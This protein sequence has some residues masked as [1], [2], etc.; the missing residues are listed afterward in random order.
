MRMLGFRSWL[1]SLPTGRRVVG[2]LFV[3]FFL[4]FFFHS[5]N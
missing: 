4:V 2:E 1:S 3:F 5:V